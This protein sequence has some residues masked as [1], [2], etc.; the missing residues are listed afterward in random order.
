MPYAVYPSPVGT[1]V[2]KSDGQRWQP[3]PIADDH[4]WG[5]QDHPEVVADLSDFESFVAEVPP[6]PEQTFNAAIAAG[7]PTGLG[8]SLALGESDRNAFS[9]MLL[10]ISVAHSAGALDLADPQVIAD[11]DGV[12]H[13]V[14]G[15]Q[16]IGLMLAYGQHFKS[17]WNELKRAQA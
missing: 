17:L 2:R 10:L 11:K 16:F 3:F 7:F 12:P 5:G 13:E 9:Q 14:T 1:H 4:D 8:Y 15:E 6:T